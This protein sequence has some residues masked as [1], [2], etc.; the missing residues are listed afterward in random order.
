[1]GPPHLT[2]YATDDRL[3]SIG[4]DTGEGP[5]G[6]AHSDGVESRGWQVHLE[7]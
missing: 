2:P 6:P 4:E 7:S 1:M 5:D 3:C